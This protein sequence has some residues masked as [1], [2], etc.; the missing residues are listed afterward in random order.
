VYHPRGRRKRGQDVVDA[1]EFMA[2]PVREFDGFRTDQT[3]AAC[4]KNFHP[5]EIVPPPT[6][7][8]TKKALWKCRQRQSSNG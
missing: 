4:D 5:F 8:N 3:V 6:G 2:R 1:D 7:R